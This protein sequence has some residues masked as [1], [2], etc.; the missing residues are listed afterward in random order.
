MNLRQIFRGLLPFAAAIENTQEVTGFLFTELTELDLA[1]IKPVTPQIILLPE[2]STKKR[3]V[4]H[5]L[6]PITTDHQQRGR[7]GRAEQ[8]P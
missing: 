8:L 5:V 2:E 3:A 6:A 1:Q 4:V 7:I